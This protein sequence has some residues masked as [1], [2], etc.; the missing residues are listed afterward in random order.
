MDS[1]ITLAK[2]W[3]VSLYIVG[4]YIRDYKLGIPTTDI[5]DIDICSSLLPYEVIELANALNLKATIINES[6]L[7]V[8]IDEYEHTTFRGENNCDGRHANV[9]P[10]NALEEDA[11]RRDFTIGALYQNVLTGEIIDPTNG[12]IDIGN[13]V[14]RLISSKKYGDEYKRLTEHGGRLFRLARFLSGKLK[15]WSVAKKT[16][17][18]C[19]RFAPKVF[20]FSPR[21]CFITEWAKSNY[22]WGYLNFLKDIGFLSANNLNFYVE[23]EEY[24]SKYA[25]FYLWQ[26]SNL[27]LKEFKNIWKI[28]NTQYKLC[29]DLDIGKSINHEYE[30]V[31]TKFIFLSADEVAS[32]YG[33]SFRKIEGIKTP[34]QI[35]EEGIYKGYQIME[36]WKKLVRETY[37]KT[38]F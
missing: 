8:K 2:H 22:S 3:P 30:W 1:L 23:E 5:N 11:F 37:N 28:S 34:A 27:E 12:L 35:A 25:L 14:V 31:T 4:G 26:S 17:D 29:R 24:N 36:A 18:A 6:H 19:K 10:V 21:E 20:D 15:R 13:K 9:F 7:V 38:S 33:T 16:L 32:F